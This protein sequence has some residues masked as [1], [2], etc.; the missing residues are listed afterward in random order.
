MVFEK[1]LVM[2]PL[3]K[4]KLDCS[5]VEYE[6]NGLLLHTNLT[7]ENQFLSI[8]NKH[9]SPLEKY[10]FLGKNLSRYL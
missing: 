2:L 7:K 5:N 4:L 1:N 8:S 10:I 6:Y 3:F 9:T